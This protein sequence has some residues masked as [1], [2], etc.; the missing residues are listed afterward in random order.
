MSIANVVKR[1]GR[2]AAVAR[3]PDDGIC[4]SAE[5]LENARVHG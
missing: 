1:L 5:A 3:S 2:G 4:R